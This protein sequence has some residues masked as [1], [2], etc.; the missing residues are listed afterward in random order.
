MFAKPAGNPIRADS[1]SMHMSS[2]T[3]RIPNVSREC[4]CKFHQIQD[5]LNEGAS[6]ML[7]NHYSPF[8][9]PSIYS[10]SLRGMRPEIVTEEA[11]A[12]FRGDGPQG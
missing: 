9:F 10:V 2:R 1:S 4:E 6:T 8:H 5:S 11:A 7:Y 12:A 3:R